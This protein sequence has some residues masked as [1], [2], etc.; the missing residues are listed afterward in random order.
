MKNLIKILTI[1]CLVFYSSCSKVS[2]VEE[3][4]ITQTKNHLEEIAKLDKKSKEKAYDHYMKL[5]E[6]LSDD[7]IPF[8][9]FYLF[10]TGGSIEKLEKALSTNPEDP[11]LNYLKAYTSNDTEDTFLVYKQILKDYPHHEM[12]LQGFMNTSLNLYESTK[13]LSKKKSILIDLEKSVSRFNS[14]PREIVGIYDFTNE[15]HKIVDF[16]LENFQYNLRKVPDII[17][18]LRK[19]LEE[20]ML[21][22]LFNNIISTGFDF[23]KRPS[24]QSKTGYVPGNAGFNFQN[25]KIV[26]VTYTALQYRATESGK[27]SDLRIER[28]C[29][30]SDCSDYF[31]ISLKGNWIN[32]SG[33]GDGSLVISVSKDR[34]LS[35]YIFGKGGG[36]THWLDFD[37]KN[38]K[39]S[40]KVYEMIKKS[41]DEI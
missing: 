12:T 37:L 3:I 24:G 34:Y 33:G 16:I 20:E 40:N 5:K 8:V 29:G 4:P 41:F 38:S 7:L 21:F 30:F 28:N 1:V 14:L 23:D 36:W 25:N 32:Q 19:E 6:G 27:I 10:Q 11:N 39:N 2:F 17:I 9:D 31:D 13:S 26:T 18:E 35:V 22:E 15:D